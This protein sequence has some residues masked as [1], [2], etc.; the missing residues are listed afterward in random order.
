M[1]TLKLIYSKNTQNFIFKN[2]FH[3]Y[4]VIKYNTYEI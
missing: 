1:Y 4:E 3:K 2:R